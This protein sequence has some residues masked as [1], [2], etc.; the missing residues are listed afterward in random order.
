MLSAFRSRSAI[1][2]SCLIFS[3]VALA[4][5]VQWELPP[6]GASTPFATGTPDT[7]EPSGMAPPGGQSLAGYHLTYVNDFNRPG[8]PLG[9]DLFS[10]KPGG[11][12]NGQF[13][14]GHVI[15]TQGLLR[16]K[17]YR[18]SAY[19]NKW[20][21]GG[22]C[23]CEKSMTYGAYFVRS[24]V[25][26]AGPNSVELLWPSNNVWPP[27]LDFNEDLY[28]VDLT[29][30]TVHWSNKADFRI[31]RINMLQWHTWG[32]IWTPHYILYVVDGHPWHEFSNSSAIPAI[33]MT[34][35]FEQVTTCPPK[36]PS[37]PSSLLI[38]WV[39]EYQRNR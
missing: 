10:D 23:Q 4:I 29:T 2:V 36:C 38:D 11:D 33:P 37:R 7:H 5:S 8:T 34:L 19:A 39:A 28:H 22:L 21:T 6:S 1:F 16:L 13:S 14:P 30:G 24:R 15:V 20:V 17:T 31:M 3:I 12:P 26:G 9:W 27:E 35:D 25:T 32:M 18:D